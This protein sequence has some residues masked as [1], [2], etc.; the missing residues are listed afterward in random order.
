MTETLPIA[1]PN[2]T[3]R[4]PTTNLVNHI[5]WTLNG[6]ETVPHNMSEAMGSQFTK[7]SLES[8]VDCI[9]GMCGKTLSILDITRI[10]PLSV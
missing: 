9:R 5:H 6:P 7:V 3:D 4:L 2:T 10:K 1:N 8:F